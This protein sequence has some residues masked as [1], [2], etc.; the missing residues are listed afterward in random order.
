MALKKQKL[1]NA[2]L[3]FVRRFACEL[4]GCDENFVFKTTAEKL[5]AAGGCWCSG[6]TAV[7]PRLASVSVCRPV[8]SSC[9]PYPTNAVSFTS[10]SDVSDFT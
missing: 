9:A 7:Q 2:D 1:T 6:L 4:D 10:K 8:S 5:G 3:K